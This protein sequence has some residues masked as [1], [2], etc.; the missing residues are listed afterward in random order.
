LPLEDKGRR[1]LCDD[2]ILITAD[3]AATCAGRCSS[4]DDT[5]AASG[6]GYL[7]FTRA[8]D[9]GAYYLSAATRIA[10]CSVYVGLPGQSRIVADRRREPEDMVDSRRT[11]ARADK[12]SRTGLSGAGGC[13]HAQ[14]RRRF[15]SVCDEAICFGGSVVPNDYA[16]DGG[17]SQSCRAF[18][19]VLANQKRRHP[20]RSRMC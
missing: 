16:R 19:G 11:F 18:Q 20:A 10:Q 6:P 2:T 17:D 8:W 1:R 3:G 15:G 13:F 4:L 7:S 5:G 14:S 9:W 12:S